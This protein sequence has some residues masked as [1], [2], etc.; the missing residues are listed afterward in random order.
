MPIQTRSNICPTCNG[1]K[2]TQTVCPKCKGGHSKI[3]CGFCKGE[4][5]YF[6]TCVDCNGSG[7]VDPPQHGH[8]QV[9]GRSHPC[10]ICAQLWE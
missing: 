7:T 1:K 6:E 9:H 3:N 4:G 10:E 2:K 8:C 5:K